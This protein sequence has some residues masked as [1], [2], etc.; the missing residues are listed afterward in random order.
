MGAASFKIET[1]DPL[2]SQTFNIECFVWDL[3]VAQRLQT[4]FTNLGLQLFK[5]TLLQL[6]TWD[7]KCRLKHIIF[8][9]P[10]KGQLLKNNIAAYTCNI[11]LPIH[12][13]ISYVLS[14]YMFQ[15]C[16][17]KIQLYFLSKY[18]TVR[19]IR[20]ILYVFFNTNSF[21]LLFNAWLLYYYAK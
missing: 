17:F 12:Q 21:S 15:R 13:N 4:G 7:W 2:P 19:E 9:K 5:D 14:D 6:S 20:T 8:K 10:G 1:L 11:K 3:K 16:R 18:Q